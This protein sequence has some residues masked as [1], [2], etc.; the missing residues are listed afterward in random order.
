M[1]YYLVA[2][3]ELGQEIIDEFSDEDGRDYADEMAEEYRSSFRTQIK[4]TGR[5]AAHLLADWESDG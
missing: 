3:L 2:E 5:P 4:V 1:P